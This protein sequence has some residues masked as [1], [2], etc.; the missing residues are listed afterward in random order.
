MASSN[1]RDRFN[2]YVYVPENKRQQAQ[3]DGEEAQRRVEVPPASPA[4]AGQTPPIIT[5]YEPTLEMPP[6]PFVPPAPTGAGESAHKGFPETAPADLSSSDMP[7]S[8]EEEALRNGGKGSLAC[9]ILSIVFI[10]TVFLGIVLSII[11]IAVGN[12]ANKKS[13]YSYGR[14]ARSLGIV[15]LVFSLIAAVSMIVAI[16]NY[17]FMFAGNVAPVEQPF[18]NG[19][20]TQNENV[21]PV[22]SEGNANANGNIA[23]AGDGLIT[24]D[25]YGS[26]LSPMTPEQNEAQNVV[27]ARLDEI[28]EGDPDILNSIATIVEDS[29]E[30]EMG[31]PWEDNGVNINE[32]MNWM[33]EGFE[34]EVLSIEIDGNGAL[35]DVYLYSRDIYELTAQINTQLEEYIKTLDSPDLTTEEFKAN[36]SRIFNTIKANFDKYSASFAEFSLTSRGGNWVINGEDWDREMEELFSLTEQ[37]DSDVDDGMNVNGNTGGNANGA[38]A[39]QSGNA[40]QTSVLVDWQPQGDMR[41]FRIVAAGDRLSHTLFL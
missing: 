9:G 32:Y 10:P 30:K 41:S 26:Y 33:T 19:N 2:R 15:G 24:N 29:W 28:R 5:P 4:E 31:F 25:R 12:V 34:Y 40:R 20:E 13:V 21:A 23:D 1:N 38:Q 35:V 6:V 22:I 11:A 37:A 18:G 39:N 17:S 14:A 3:Q 27:L 7:L 36:F 16:T 8:P